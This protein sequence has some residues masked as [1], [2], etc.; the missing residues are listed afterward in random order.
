MKPNKLILFLALL[1][2]STAWGQSTQGWAGFLFGGQS[3]WPGATRAIQQQSQ[4][5]QTVGRDRYALFGAG[6]YFRINRWLVGVNASA[7]VNQRA[8]AAGVSPT[9]ESS[10]S[11]AHLWVGWVAWQSKRAKVHPSIGPG[12]NAFNIN[13]TRTDGSVTTATLDGFATDFGCTFD[14]QLTQPST[15][16]TISAGPMLSVRA[17]YRL[18]T[19]SREWHGDSI[20]PTTLSP[21][22]YSPHGFY[23]TLGIGMGGFRNRH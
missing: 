4:L 2:S 14:W 17:G 11:N 23:I 3:V 20:K 16:Q 1:F 18:T 9:V 5:L 21:S 8:S 19:G 6:A 15:T 13:S 10:A 7:L 12:I 22:R